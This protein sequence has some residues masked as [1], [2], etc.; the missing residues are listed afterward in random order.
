M[1]LTLKTGMELFLVNSLDVPLEVIG[2][3]ECFIAVRTPVRSLAQMDS[4]DVP[5]E[6]TG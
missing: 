4:I 6:S 1:F 3:T 5:L 2:L